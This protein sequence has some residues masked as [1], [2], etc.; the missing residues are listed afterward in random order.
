GIGALWQSPLFGLPPDRLYTVTINAD[1]GGAVSDLEADGSIRVV[2][3]RTSAPLRGTTLL[4]GATCFVAADN[5]EVVAQHEAVALWQAAASR[6]PQP[7]KTW[8]ALLILA[9]VV[10]AGSFGLAP[11]E[12]AASAG[13]VLMVLT[14]VLTPGAAARALDMQLLF[15]LAGSIGLG[16]IVISSGLADVIAD[17]IRTASGGNTALVVIVF[18]VATTVMT[19]FVTN[20]ATAS[21]LTPV[22]VG[23]ATEL[24]ISPVILLA[25]IGTCVSFT[26]IN[27]LSHQ[28]NMMVMR[29]GGY[30][31]RSFAM[32][33]V[34]VLLGSLATAC[35]VAYLLLRG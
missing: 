14:G 20:A 22:G 23:I 13:A 27:P 3:A 28:T 11:V 21:I 18:A 6:V 15:I 29:P 5:A 30:T 4:P 19:N 17:A 1:S 34:P 25:L 7:G 16:A 10:V 31:L 8:V 33:G 24:G 26:F 12:L 32:F 35:A 9:S 2:A